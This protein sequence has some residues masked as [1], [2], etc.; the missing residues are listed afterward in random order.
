M[1]NVYMARA[2]H[3][4]EKIKFKI[5][6]IINKVILVVLDLVLEDYTA[7]FLDKT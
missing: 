4:Q 6:R 5:I 3:F 1:M 2:V 7:S